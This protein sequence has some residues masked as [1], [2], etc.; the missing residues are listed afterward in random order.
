MK[1]V[2][3]KVAMGAATLAASFMLVGCGQQTTT[4]SSS[5]HSSSSATRSSESKSSKAYR[6]ANRLIRNHDYQG[7]KE[8]LDSV[9]NPSKKAKDLNTDLQ[10]YLTAQDSY[11]N[12]DYDKAASNLKNVK[13][14]SSAMKSAYSDL[15]DQITSAKKGSSSSST[16]ASATS[17]VSHV[18]ANS[19]SSS[20]TNSA[21]SSSSSSAA[22]NQAVSDQ[23][24][25]EVVNNFANKMN[26]NGSQGYEIIPTG[27]NGNVYRLEV[28]QNNKDNTVA[29]MVGIYQYNSQ[30]GSVT[31][32]N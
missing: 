4:S 12:G 29:N 23:T 32:L 20:N 9:N 15:Q 17:S 3:K 5:S 11:N 28:R 21:S 22:A 8:Q 14:S 13:S 25:S 7:A 16:A 24:S 18:A 1:T 26:F 31:K 27:K 30:S 2:I 19:S 6:A 10:N